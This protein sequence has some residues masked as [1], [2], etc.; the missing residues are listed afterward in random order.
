MGTTSIKYGEHNV[1]AEDI[2]TVSY[3]FNEEHPL[4]NQVCVF[5]GTLEKIIR[6]EAMQSVVDVGGKCGDGLKKKTII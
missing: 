6:K 3:E 5:T 4:V 2:K 1:M